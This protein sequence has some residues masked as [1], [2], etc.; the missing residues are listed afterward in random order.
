MKKH[1]P[2]LFKLNDLGNGLAYYTDAPSRPIWR[3]AAMCRALCGKGK[4]HKPGELQQ[5]ARKKKNGV[6]YTRAEGRVK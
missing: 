2:Y 1:T 6:G 4:S 5:G 3:Y